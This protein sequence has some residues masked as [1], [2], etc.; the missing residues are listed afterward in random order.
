MKRSRRSMSRML[1]WLA[2]PLVGGFMIT[3]E[4]SA[5]PSARSDRGSVS[6]SSQQAR[7]APSRTMVDPSVQPAGGGCRECGPA[8]CRH[9]HKHHHGC[10]DGVCV[11][12]CPVRP[13]T[14]GFYTTQWRRWPG[15]GVVPVSGTQA[16]MPV[17]PPKSAVPNADE[18][19][20]APRPDELPEP[21][22]PSADMEG[23]S[24][25]APEP[26]AVPANPQATDAEAAV[27]PRS[28]PAS[29]TPEPPAAEPAKKPSDGN[30]F[31]DSS[32]RKVRRKIPVQTAA[33]PAAKTAAGRSGV[34]A[35]SHTA[36]ATPTRSGSASRAVPRVAFDPP[37]PTPRAGAARTKQQR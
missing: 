35:A 1:A 7:V 11:A 9:C 12:A 29:E 6:R 13:G 28:A 4:A 19:S 16:L 21:E 15:Q 34:I 20:F 22:G 32:A 23:E 26:D 17:Q 36:D 3:P 5:Q 37:L 10:R 14:Y 27:E 8:G 25:L 31:D 33:A 2:I 18:E 24:P 30:L